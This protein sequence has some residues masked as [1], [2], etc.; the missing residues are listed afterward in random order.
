MINKEETATIHRSRPM[1]DY[2]SPLVRAI[3]PSG[4]RKFFDLVSASKDIISL[5]VGEPDFCTPWHVREAAVYSLEK[6]RT[7][8]TPNAGVAN[9]F[10]VDF[11]ECG[12]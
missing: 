10:V 6:G 7:K 5:G 11:S 4:I 3:P 8:Y 9:N 2:L 1:G 12:F